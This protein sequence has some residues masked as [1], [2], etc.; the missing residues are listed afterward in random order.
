MTS[1][2][3]VRASATAKQVRLLVEPTAEMRFWARFLAVL[4]FP[5]RDH[6]FAKILRVALVTPLAHVANLSFEFQCYLY[7][8]FHRSRAAKLGHALCMPVIVTATLASVA[9]LNLIAAVVCAALLALWYLVQSLFNRMFL[10]GLVMVLTTAGAGAVA[11]VWNSSLASAPML[12][13]EP[14]MVLL[15]FS[16]LQT[17]SHLSEPDI[18]PRTNGTKDWVPVG[19]YFFGPQQHRSVSLL[20]IRRVTRSA[21]VFAAGVFNEFWGSWR[22]LPVLVVRA[23]W[24]V[25]YQPRKRARLEMLSRQILGEGNPAI[26][27]IGTGG[28]RNWPYD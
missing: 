1:S 14:A 13:A 2:E 17:F 15:I 21:F 8:I 26:D 20:L 28:T 9:R 27:V 23:M 3:H 25:G 10:L 6:L 22:L 19:E 12:W 24:R 16:A 4:V 5:R 7:G 11:I 18:P